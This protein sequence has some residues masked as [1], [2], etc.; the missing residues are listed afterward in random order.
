MDK[1]FPFKTLGVEVKPEKTFQ[2]FLNSVNGTVTKKLPKQIMPHS[3]GTAE[4]SIPG[5]S[6]DTLFKVLLANTTNAP[7]DPNQCIPDEITALY[8]A[9]FPCGVTLSKDASAGKSMTRDQ[10]ISILG[11]PMQVSDYKG[12][13][14]QVYFI[15]ESDPSNPDKAAVSFSFSTDSKNKGQFVDVTISNL[16]RL[17]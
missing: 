6:S 14:G 12:A 15:E 10:I 13:Q 3:S 4:V 1:I 8:S 16:K 2:D 5:I 17:K 7:L 11:K 9:E